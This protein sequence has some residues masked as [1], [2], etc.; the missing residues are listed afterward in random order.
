[1][2][3]L[4]KPQCPLCGNKILEKRCALNEYLIYFCSS[5]YLAFTYPMPTEKQLFDYYNNSY[6]SSENFLPGTNLR[7]GYRDYISKKNT[8]VANAKHIMKKLNRFWPEKPGK[9]L[10]IGCAAGFFLDY[11]RSLGWEV[12][13]LDLSKDAVNYAKESLRL[14][15]SNGDLIS[16]KLPSNNFDACLSVGTIDHM[17]DP[18]AAFAKISCVLKS[19]G[20]FLMTI[21]DISGPVP[22]H[23]RP[24]E[25]LFYFSRK[26]VKLALEKYGFEVKHLSVYWLK[27]SIG[28]LWEKVSYYTKLP[29]PPRWIFNLKLGLRVPIN[30]MVVIATKK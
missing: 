22:L 6:F 23:Y 16:S 20:L 28:E 9:L 30:E 26:S 21:G 12:Q 19:G 3:E 10:E 4:D 8:H 14:N 15:A 25:H 11:F 1:M 29:K 13:G 27:F 7:I 18:L 5:C 2:A 24:P 17:S